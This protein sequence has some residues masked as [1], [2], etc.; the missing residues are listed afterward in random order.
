M[1]VKSALLNGFIKEE[2][3]MEQPSG[4][5]SVAFWDYAFKLNKALYGLNYVDDIKLVLDDGDEHFD[6]A[7]EDDFIRI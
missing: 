2:V 7:N 1:D 6:Q 5:E 3:Y 4:F